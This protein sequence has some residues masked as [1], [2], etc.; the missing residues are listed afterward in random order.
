MVGKEYKTQ[1]KALLLDDLNSKSDVSPNGMF[2]IA[3]ISRQY[4]GRVQQRTIDVVMDT[5][6]WIRNT[7]CTVAI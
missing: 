7:L 5:S 3:E 4:Q 2:A 1:I 6:R